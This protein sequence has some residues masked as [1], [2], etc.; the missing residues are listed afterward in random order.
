[1]KSNSYIFDKVPKSA[2]QT[3]LI[4]N[5]L[6]ANHYIEALVMLEQDLE[7]VA[8]AY[9]GRELIKQGFKPRKKAKYGGG[10]LDLLSNARQGR[11]I[12]I[13]SLLFDLSLITIK[14]KNA[15]DIVRKTRNTYAHDFE[16]ACLDE[17]KVHKA[18]KD[19]LT[20]LIEMEK[21]DAIDP[22]D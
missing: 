6:K 7:K 14:Q 9:L 4:E 22:D 21:L 2:L 3:K 12:T 11:H 18:V 19:G 10:K 13:I 5:A 16:H 8:E 1:M 15:F 17:R 20:L